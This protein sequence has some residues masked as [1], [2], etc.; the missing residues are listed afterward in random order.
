[1]VSQNFLEVTDRSQQWA[2]PHQIL[3][4][5][6]FAIEDDLKVTFGFD[7]QSNEMITA[8][9]KMKIT[10]GEQISYHSILR[11]YAII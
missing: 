2:G 3:N 8:T 4:N 5:V 10:I 1:M 7:I 11:Y 9:W 6:H